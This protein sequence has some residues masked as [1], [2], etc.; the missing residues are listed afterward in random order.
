MFERHRKV[1][2]ERTFAPQ[3]TTTMAKP[4]PNVL[5]SIC[6]D[7]LSVLSN[8]CRCLS[9]S[10]HVLAIVVFSE[11]YKIWYYNLVMESLVCC[12]DSLVCCRDVLDHEI[13]EHR[14]KCKEGNNLKQQLDSQILHTQDLQVLFDHQS[15]EIIDPLQKD[16]DA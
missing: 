8:G 3:M 11:W 2:M 4:H 6:S 10:A 15:A 7:A 13:K 1:F 5:C 16:C 14:K 12:Q 9:A